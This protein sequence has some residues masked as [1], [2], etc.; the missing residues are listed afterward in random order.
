MEWIAMNLHAAPSPRPV[1]TDAARFR[2]ILVAMA[3][4]MVLATATAQGD[5]WSKISPSA[6]EEMAEK[7]RTV[8]IVG[9]AAEAVDVGPAAAGKS[10]SERVAARRDAVRQVQDKVLAAM[11]AEGGW[12]VRHRYATIPYV[13]AE[14]DY[15]ALGALAGLTPVVAV[16]SDQRVAP[17]DIESNETIGATSVQEIFGLTGTGVNVAIIDTGI[18]LAHPDLATSLVAGRRFLNQGGTIDDNVQDDQGHGSHAAGI[19]TSDG[20]V[21]PRG[22]APDAGLV[23]V[24]ALDVSGG[25]VSDLAA[26]VDWIADNNTSFTV[27]VRFINMSLEV[28]GGLGELPAQCPCD[29][30][31]DFQVLTAAIGSA[32]DEG[33]VCI[34]A[35]GND[36]DT[37]LRYPACLSKVVSV[38]SSFDTN[39]AFAPS[40]AQQFPTT[41][42]FNQLAGGFFAECNHTTP[43]IPDQ[44]ACFS[45]RNPC[46]DFAAPGYRITS[47]LMGSTENN[48][49]GFGTSQATAHVTAALALLQQADGA[50]SS[51]ELLQLLHDTAVEIPQNQASPGGTQVDRIDVRRAVDRA[52]H[53]GVGDWM[54]Y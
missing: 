34:G 8:V 21:A 51:A 41:G 44:L 19:I 24:K 22:I 10:K 39:Y 14:V 52:L 17:A 23:V 16:Q 32:F 13:V 1:V 53:N 36:G 33:I 30:L 40:T 7:G 50:L 28:L 47:V 25:F 38:G 27:P 54:L 49:D 37:V 3:L 12:R 9:L 46:M 29:N 31:P 6:L 35:A 11:N 42:T 2:P 20:N 43:V 5:P 15:S 26:G 48:L 18:D 4:C 45:N